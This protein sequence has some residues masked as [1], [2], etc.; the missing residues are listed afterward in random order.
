MSNK[1]QTKT[2]CAHIHTLHTQKVVSQKINLSF[3][4]CEKIKFGDKNKAFN[5]KYFVFL[6]QQQRFF[7]ETLETHIKNYIGII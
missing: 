4:M 6:H 7:C 1:F 2:S 5:K 3:G